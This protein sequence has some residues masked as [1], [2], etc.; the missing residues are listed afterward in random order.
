MSEG[1]LCFVDLVVLQRMVA[2]IIVSM[3]ANQA[4]LIENGIDTAFHGV[5][6]AARCAVGR[7]K[8]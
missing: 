2:V 8:K 4:S 5:F 1:P 6:A 3:V 7:C